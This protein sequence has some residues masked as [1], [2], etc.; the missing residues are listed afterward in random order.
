MRLFVAINLPDKIKKELAD[1][2]QGLR[3]FGL[4]KPV[5]EGDIH[6]TLKFLGDA[7]PE[8]V[9]P[10]L[11]RVEHKKFDISLKGLGAFPSLNYIKVV[12][13]GCEKG[14]K[15]T[16]TLHDR[17]ES[18]LPEFKRDNNFHPHATLARVKFPKD[19]KGLIDF[20]QQNQGDFGEFEVE[21]FDLMKSELSRAGPEYEVV[22][23]FPLK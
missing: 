6:L 14:F 17:I 16:V 11:G 9:V 15:E 19:K 3:G 22:K 1:L 2:G 8:D 18:V 13:A 20:I 5:E 12:W 4:I 10:N 21:T 23:S 7:K